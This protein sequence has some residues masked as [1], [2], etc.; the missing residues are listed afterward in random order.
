[1]SDEKQPEVTVATPIIPRTTPNI[2]RANRL[3]SLKS[4]P[5]FYDWLRIS[6]ELV[7]EA[8]AVSID[9]GGW[10]A[11]QITVLKCRAQAAKEHHQ[12][13]IAKMLDA[14]RI[15]VEE[16]RV[17]MT[18]EP[19]KTTAEMIEQGDLVRIKTLEHFD[20]MDGRVAGSY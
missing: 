11:Q 19:Q 20:E 13:M 1:M 7:D 8:A 12:L 18:V 4:H 15:G 3:M 14:I 6:Q 9:Y 5:G 16:A 10:D 17:Q 2:E